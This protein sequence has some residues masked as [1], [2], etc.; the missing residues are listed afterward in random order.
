MTMVLGNFTLPAQVGYTGH[1]NGLKFM[2]AIDITFP[3][4]F[5]VMKVI[6]SLNL[7]LS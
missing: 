1:E 4:I 6:K 7:L 3:Q 5:F 2:E